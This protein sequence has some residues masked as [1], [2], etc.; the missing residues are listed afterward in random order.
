MIYEVS[1]DIMKLYEIARLS[2]GT[3][4]GYVS[5]SNV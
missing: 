5:L 2:I 1:E 4:K 3:I